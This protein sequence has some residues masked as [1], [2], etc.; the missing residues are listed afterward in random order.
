MAERVPCCKRAGQQV[1]GSSASSVASSLGVLIP[2][3]SWRPGALFCLPNHADVA[4]H[5]PGHTL[6][7][8]GPHVFISPAEGKLAGKEGASGSP[9]RS[10]LWLFLWGDALATEHLCE[11]TD[12][13]G[14]GGGWQ[15]KMGGCSRAPLVPLCFDNSKK[16]K[17]VFSGTRP[18]PGLSTFHL[19]SCFFPQTTV[20]TLILQKR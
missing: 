15:E 11:V 7:L 1:W 3:G 12:Q 9:L 20:V 14:T 18:E 8:S 16:Q 10:F 2:K 4:L 17:L 13:D 5:Y 6:L 19:L